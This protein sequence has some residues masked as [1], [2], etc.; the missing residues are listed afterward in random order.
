VTDDG[1]PVPLSVQDRSQWDSHLI[2]EGIGLV[3][4]AAAEVGAGAYTIQAAIAAL[5]AEAADFSDTDWPQI[6]VLYRMLADLDPSPVVALNTAIALGQVSGPEAAL[7]A[8]DELGE[9]TRLRR[10]RPFHTA[11]AI[12]LSELGRAGEAE[13]AY[14][15]ALEC[16]GNDAESDYISARAADLYR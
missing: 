3:R 12:T 7:R 2:A 9:D 13:E 16:A 14:A 4:T 5:H 8:L 15:A 6:L 1:A 11:R 10:H